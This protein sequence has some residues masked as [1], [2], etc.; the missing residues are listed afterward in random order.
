M[1]NNSSSQQD[2]PFWA[3]RCSPRP[4]NSSSPPLRPSLC[5]Q[6]CSFRSGM[7]GEKERDQRWED[8]KKV[9]RSK[10]KHTHTD[11]KKWK[12]TE[13]N[14]IFFIRSVHLLKER[15]RKRKRIWEGSWRFVCQQEFRALG[16]TNHSPWSGSTDAALWLLTQTCVR[17]GWPGTELPLLPRINP[18]LHT[19]E[20]SLL[21]VWSDCAVFL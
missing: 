20:F 2:R 14:R 19:L 13:Q 11:A 15:E 18:E 7:K 5:G 10:L 6:R 17:Q 12:G 1:P 4:A 16:E 3:S 8:R 21:H 9:I